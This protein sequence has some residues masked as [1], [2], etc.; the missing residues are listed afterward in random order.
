MLQRAEDERAVRDCSVVG[1]P[2]TTVCGRYAVCSFPLDALAPGYGILVWP[3]CMDGFCQCTGKL[4]WDAA[5]EPSGDICV[6]NRLAGLTR[7]RSA[8]VCLRLAIGRRPACAK[9][10]T[11]RVRCAAAALWGHANR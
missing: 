11:C 10:S 9:R 3:A 2:Q 6:T 4:G 1:L 8:M 7:E 5:L